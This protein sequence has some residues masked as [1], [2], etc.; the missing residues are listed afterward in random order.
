MEAWVDRFLVALGAE[1][2]CS[3]H[4]VM[5]YRNDLMQLAAYLTREGV[6][7]WRVVLPEQVTE[8]LQSLRE[9]Q[10]ASST[11]ARK[12]AA[13]KSFFQYLK[14]TGEIEADV[15]LHLFAPRVD[16]YVPHAISTDEVARLLAAPTRMKTPE[17]MRDAAMLQLLY[18]T[19]MRVSEL[20]ALDQSDLD[21]ATGGIRCEGRAARE[22]LVSLTPTAHEAL[23]RYLATGRP[24]IARAHGS[25]KE[26]LFLNHRGQRLTRQGFW[27]LLKGY[28]QSASVRNVTPHTLRHTF[29]AHALT[30][31]HHLREVQTMLGHVSISTTQIYQRMR[32]APAAQAPSG[33]LIG[34]DVVKMLGGGPSAAPLPLVAGGVAAMMPTSGEIAETVVAHED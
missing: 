25:D 24:I 8:Y 17:S 29:A 22:R 3:P 4:T 9:R 7:V 34:L 12:T 28:A 27:L 26:A 15:A 13:A 33:A 18:A 23:R 32:P 14:Q 11:I 2:H 19:G 6:T 31:G 20:V 5:A 30:T 21:L 16:R 1:K 10:Y